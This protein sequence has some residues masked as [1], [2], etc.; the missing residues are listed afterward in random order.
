[1]HQGIWDKSAA[2]SFEVR[3]KKL[4]IV[5]YGN[6][7]AQLSV[8]AEAMGME[9]YYYDVVE[10]LQL[11]NAR[12]CNTLKELLELSDFVTLHVDG[13]AANKNFFGPAEFEA[14]KDG[15]IFLNLS[16][17]H[18][19][20]IP[21]LVKNIKSGKVKGAAVDVF[22]YEPVNNSEE[23]INELRGL[24]NV[25]LTPHIG[26][27]TSEAQENIANFVPNRIMQYINTGNTYQSVNF[28]NIQLPELNN[29][30]RLIHVHANVP[31]VLANINN[32]LASNQVNI[33][34]QYLKTNEQIGYVITDIDKAYDKEVIEEMKR[35]AHTIKF[36]ILY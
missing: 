31:G 20:D 12:K 16:R 5:G 18:I 28:P 10:K 13:R 34:G 19:V 3:G 36:R 4:G 27:S 8:L 30:H 22:P 26:G 29:A 21:S 17:G 23:F 33:L 14:M 15:V 6:I 7:G 2:G 11:G 9:V 24:P 35:V 25:I 32:V 1:M